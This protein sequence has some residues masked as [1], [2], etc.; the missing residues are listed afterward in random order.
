MPGPVLLVIP[1]GHDATNVLRGGVL[2]ALIASG[3]KV[4]VA[5]PFARDPSFLAEFNHPS[6]V[7]EILEPFVPTLFSYAVDSVLGEQFVRQSGLTA[8]R[9]Q[10]ERARLLEPWTG[11]RPLVAVKRL[12]SLLPVSR[13]RW[14]AVER[15]LTAT[16]A[17]R[18]L[19]NRHRPV[20]V[21]TSTAGFFGAELPVLAEAGRRRLP[22]LGIDSG[23]D[24]LSS[25]F[26]TIRPVDYLAVWN[27]PM[28]DE[29]VKYHGLS[30]WRVEVTGSPQLDVYFSSDP[31]GPR[32]PFRARLGVAPETR[33]VTLATAPASVYDGTPQVVEFL[34]STI[35]SHAL[36]MPVHLLV[37]V[38]PRDTLE[39]YA[40]WARTPGVTVEKPMARVELARTSDTFDAVAPTADQRRH[41]AA[42]LAHSDVIVNFASTTALEAFVF[43]TPVVNIGFDP[44][45][46]RPLALSIRRYFSYEHYRPLPASGAVRVAHSPASLLEEVRAYLG[47]PSRDRDARR[48][49]LERLLPRR[50]GC[51]AER[52]AALVQRAMR[53]AGDS[54]R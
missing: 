33:I 29:A 4:V 7:H 39:R 11:R 46:G 14:F 49:M 34:A 6:T 51:S 32:A 38:H 21:A 26:H 43:D 12:A 15:R 16:S 8:P 18:D 37:R 48:D 22:T 53:E 17:C 28:R 25:K 1:T 30:P 41:L 13:R 19:F 27:E 23:W 42:T 20:A 45:P 3:T 9:L 54:P 2:R 5:S 36:G 35:A 24:N 40:R 52:V 47:D 50:D 44:E 10:L 31:A